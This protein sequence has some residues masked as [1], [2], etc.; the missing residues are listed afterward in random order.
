MQI[1]ADLSPKIRLDLRGG[2][3]L[4]AYVQN[5]PVMFSDPLGLFTEYNSGTLL[6]TLVPEQIAWDNGMT[7][8]NQGDCN[9]AGI[10]L[11]E[12]L[13]EQVLTLLT[14]GES[15]AIARSSKKNYRCCI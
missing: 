5:N 13:G 3:N 8:F 10:Y 1:P 11:V 9:S 14:L 2:I 6:R 12:M 15:Q 7:S 4:Y